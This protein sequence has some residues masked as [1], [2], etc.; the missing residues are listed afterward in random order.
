MVWKKTKK[1]HTETILE[2]KNTP[3]INTKGYI[4]ILLQIIIRGMG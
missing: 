3:K 2:Y 4:Y 1:K